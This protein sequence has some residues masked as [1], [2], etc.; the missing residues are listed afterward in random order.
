MTVLQP[1]NGGWWKR[2]VTY[3]YVWLMTTIASKVQREDLMKCF[4]ITRR[5]QFERSAAR[6]FIFR[7]QRGER[8]DRERCMAGSSLSQRG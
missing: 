2:V 3:H 1:E 6:G 4:C 7:L 8:E 5:I